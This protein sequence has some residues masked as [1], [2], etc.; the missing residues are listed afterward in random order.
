MTDEIQPN[1]NPD[2]AK[3]EAE[4]AAFLERNQEA[5]IV[6]HPQA[7][8]PF[9]KMAWGDPSVSF[10]LPN[11][12]A[13][14]SELVEA[15][16]RLFL[17]PRLSALY[18]TDR[19][20]LEI[21]FTARALDD[22]LGEVADRRFEFHIDGQLLN[23]FFGDSSK[24]LLT[25]AKHAL[26]PQ[27]SSTGFR[28]LMSF[29][30]YLEISENPPA[31]E[32]LRKFILSQ[33]DKP[34]SFWIEP[35][36]WRDEETL[37]SLRHVSFYLRYYD[38]ISPI[39]V[40]H[41]PRDSMSVNPKERYLIGQFPEKITSR[42]LNPAL[43]SF[44]LAAAEAT[45]AENQFLYC[46]RIIEFVSSNYFKLEKLNQV[47]RILSE[48]ALMST[49]DSSIDRLVPLIRDEGR[50]E[51]NRFKAVVN[52]LVRKEIIWPDICANAHAFTKE[53][54]FD[55]GFVLPKLV[56]G[57][58]DISRFGPT[59]MNAL[60]GHFRDI[61]NALAHGGEIQAGKVIL[62]TAK[63]AK[64]LQPWAHLIVAVAGEVVLHENHT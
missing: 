13:E 53:V 37:T 44:Y 20:A 27:A 22:S 51:V 43:L 14:R 48:P 28:N 40:T 15:L 26:Y 57:V 52:E 16:N 21:I 8:V 5:E 6:L 62:P 33:Y 7:K 42:T 36:E 59:T 38:S 49:L 31:D 1:K 45:H 55:G 17:P 2:L 58:D 11:T 32:E 63:N 60:A 9:V 50:Q 39:I 34:L 41:P 61:R 23:C 25:L 4:L 56:D 3:A 35:I 12:N 24:E 18:H 47:K 30:D 46:Y 19:S 54:V 29:T 64:L 10:L